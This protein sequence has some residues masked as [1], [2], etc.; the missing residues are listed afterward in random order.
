[1]KKR[2]DEEFCKCCF[3]N[4]I[5]DEAISVKKR[6]ECGDE[7]PD[8]YL[9]LRN[10]KYAVEITTIIVKKT[11]FNKN[12]SDIG[13]VEGRDRLVKK[14]EKES[15][16]QGIL[17]GEYVMGIGGPFKDFKKARR[18]I[19]NKALRY[20]LNT[21]NVGKA[22]NET[23]FKNGYAT[24]FIEKISKDSNIICAGYNSN[25]WFKWKSEVLIEAC[26]LLQEV[27]NNKKERLKEINLPKILLLRHHYPLANADIYKQYKDK[28]KNLN[29]FHS[30]FVVTSDK[31]GYFLNTRN[32][33]GNFIF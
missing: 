18:E 7:P 26:K 28:I 14:I 4:Y 10:K 22:P 8:Y 16:K 25:D 20:I 31:E 21:Q 24:C 12:L 15:H 32:K 9:K 23:I 29:F 17:N 13:Y 19:E 5:N 33:D 2:E 6:W 27:I 30:V 1:M 11:K 3:D